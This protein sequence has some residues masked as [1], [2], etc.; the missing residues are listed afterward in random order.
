MHCFLSSPH[1]ITFLC[2]ASLFTATPS[3]VAQCEQWKEVSGGVTQSV[4]G[5]QPAVRALVTY[6]GDLVAGGTFLTAGRVTVNGIARWDGSSWQ[7]IASGMGGS[8][9]HVTA[10]GVYNNDLIAGGSF[11]QA[12][13]QAAVRIARWDGSNWNSMGSGMNDEVQALAVYGN[14]LVAGGI[15]TQA[16]GVSVN[17]IARWDGTT[18]NTLGQGVLTGTFIQPMVESLTVYNG[19]LLVGGHFQHA[20]G[21]GLL[22]NHIARWNGTSWQSTTGPSG[23]G[24]GGLTPSVVRALAVYNGELIVGGH[25]T[26]AGGLSANYVARWNGNS[27]QTLGSGMNNDVLDLTV[28]NG[29]LI[30]GGFFTTAG[31]ATVNYIAAWNGTAWSAIDL[32]MSDITIGLGHFHNELYA[33]GGFQMAGGDTVNRI[34][35][36]QDCTLQCVADVSPPD[37]P[38]GV[39]NIDDLVTVIVNWNA[40]GPNVADATDDGQINIDD[41]V[42]VITSW[43]LCR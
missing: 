18:W 36:S 3:V 28:Y 38:N 7:S 16:G 4:V 34:A 13:G 43:G 24:V 32:G 2:T 31:S 10:L 27:W 19:E 15:F 39:V 21:V 29:R 6:K 22:G 42:A 23:N 41:L 9:P 35:R 30:A 14:Q 12:G 1:V 20:G 26:T 17:R 40:V 37:A 25:F 8:F 11:I 5:A 33:G